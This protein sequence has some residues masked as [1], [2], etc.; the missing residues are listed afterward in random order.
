MSLRDLPVRIRDSDE[1]RTPTELLLQ[2]IWLA[3]LPGNSVGVH[4]DFFAAGGNSLG[5]VRVV[6]AVRRQWEVR[7]PLSALAQ[8]HT[9][10]RLAAL[11]DGE[12]D[13]AETGQPSC[14]VPLQTGTGSP[15]VVFVHPLGG[16]VLWY[17]FLARM[18]PQD[19]R[20]LGVQALG[21]RP[22]AEPHRDIPSM[23]EHYL[24][25]LSSVCP[26]GELLLV[27]YSFGGLVA[28]EMAHRLEREG[29]PPRGVAVLDAAVPDGDAPTTGR[30]RL[31]WSLVGHALGLDLDV[32]ELASLPAEQLTERLL[33]AGIEQG[34][35]PEE[36]GREQLARLVEIYPVNAEAE[37]VYRLPSYDGPVDLVRA[38]GGRVD[39]R[40]VAAWR[41]ACPGTRVHDVTG[42]HLDLLS[43][44]NAPAVMAVLGAVWF[45]S[46]D[47]R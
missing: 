37:R 41:S 19:V 43:R 45:G 20:C 18:L 31:L 13:P 7:L 24:K 17:R 36:L 34:A 15:T 30:A 23:A 38:A 26:P 16:G 42:D 11:L 4:E 40:S 35:L 46:G 1:P 44:E 32:E 10:A 22:E 3:H 2:S 25:E 6:G 39:E 29:S 12:Q 9:I 8:G 33:K 14:L 5:A 47:A 28:Y 27:G 21:L